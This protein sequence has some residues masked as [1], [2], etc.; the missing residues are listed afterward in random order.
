ML[1]ISS[2]QVSLEFSFDV[3]FDTKIST[4]RK[5]C[6]SWEERKISQWGGG[7]A[8]AKIQG[9]WDDRHWRVCTFT[10]CPLSSGPHYSRGSQGK[11]WRWDVKKKEWEK[12]FLNG[13]LVFGKRMS[14]RLGYMDSS[15]TFIIDLTCE[16]EKVISLFWPLVSLY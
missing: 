16:L 6:F 13:D 1:G 2:N 11:D 4:I 14:G 5:L 12:C 8:P 3:P 9:I 7:R 10:L 15:P